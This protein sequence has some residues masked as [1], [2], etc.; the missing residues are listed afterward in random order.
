M[1][2]IYSVDSIVR[3]ILSECPDTRN[4]DAL[5]Y[6]TVCKQI[7]PAFTKLPFEKVLL[8]RKQLGLPNQAT[9]GRVRR[10]IQ[11]H[12]KELRG[13]ATVTERRY[14][15]FKTVREYVQTAE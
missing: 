15:N 10:K 5:L 7:N 2:E 6:L 1:K 14:E 11:E 13:T 4:S 12:T 8:E 9:V 3:K